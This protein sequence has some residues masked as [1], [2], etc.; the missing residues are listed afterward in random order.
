MR[1]YRGQN[2]R[3]G[4]CRFKSIRPVVVEAT[5]P[6]SWLQDCYA[7]HHKPSLMS[8]SEDAAKSKRLL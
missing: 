2:R 3:F 7:L 5:G 6:I 8:R 1:T 4:S